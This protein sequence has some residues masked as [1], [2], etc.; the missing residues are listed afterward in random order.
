[1]VVECDQQRFCTD[2]LAGL[3][4]VFHIPDLSTAIVPKICTPPLWQNYMYIE[5]RLIILLKA[6]L[7]WSFAVCICH[8][9]HFLALFQHIL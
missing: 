5:C 7:I 9:S 3:H 1:M 8:K 2:T 6:M 4:I